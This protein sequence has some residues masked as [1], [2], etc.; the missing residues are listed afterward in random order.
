MKKYMILFSIGNDRP[1]IVDAIST[2]LYEHGANIEDSQMG[3]MGGKFT[4]M[5]LFTCQEEA[6][7]NI[8]EELHA[9]HQ[10]GIETSLYE[11]EDPST[12]KTAPALPL[13]FKVTAMDHPGIVQNIVRVLYNHNVNIETLNTQ[14]HWA[15]HSG[16]PLFNLAITAGVP[17][18]TPI[19]SIKN[20]LDRLAADMDLDLT[21]MK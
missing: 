9:L 2:L 16:A 21:F 19:S 3:T 5:T 10:T 12:I 11:A 18:G 8:R 17:A 14:I 13:T 4:S 15:P 7:D 6:L 1:G 20:E